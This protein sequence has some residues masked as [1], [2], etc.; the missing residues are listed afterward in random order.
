MTERASKDRRA[1]MRDYMK[2]YV[3][4]QLHINTTDP[5]DCRILEHLRSQENIDAY[6]KQLVLANMA[7]T[8]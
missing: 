3:N 6:L 7:S 1:Y 5:Q 4:I 8:E 2:R